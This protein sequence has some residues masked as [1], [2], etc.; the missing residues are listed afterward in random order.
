MLAKGIDGQ[1]GSEH[2]ADGREIVVAGSVSDLTPRCIGQ[3]REEIGIPGKERLHS[4]LISGPAGGEQL[5]FGR[6]AFHEQTK[7]VVVV[8]LPGDV[9]GRDVK[10]EGPLINGPAG[11]WVEF[12]KPVITHARMDAVGIC[13]EMSADEFGIT[14][15]GSHQNVRLATALNEVTRNLLAIAHH[16]LRRCGFV[17]D[18]ARVNIG[19]VIQEERG[20]FDGAGEV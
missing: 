20:D 8:E 18:I 6:A 13:I 9:V 3:S 17:V 14:E 1:T 15:G 16:V 4:G 5:D 2:Q 19:V 10:A 7:N 12:W 11:L